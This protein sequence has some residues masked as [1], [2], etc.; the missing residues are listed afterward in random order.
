M[1]IQYSICGFVF[2][3]VRVDISYN[4]IDL[5]EFVSSSVCLSKCM[6]NSECEKRVLTAR[7]C[8]PHYWNQRRP[9]SRAMWP[10]DIEGYCM[11]SR[12]NIRDS[13]WGLRSMQPLT[14]SQAQIQGVRQLFRC[15][16]DRTEW[17]LCIRNG[18]VNK[19]HKSDW[20]EPFHLAKWS[21]IVWIRTTI[22]IMLWPLMSWPG[23]SCPSILW[24]LTAAFAGWSV[25]DASIWWWSW[26]IAEW[27]EIGIIGR[28]ND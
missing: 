28:L 7:E 17:L 22:D 14:L 13:I 20:S 25:I 4:K 23:I 24:S 5:F 6:A 8:C 18:T 9:S 21:Q 27:S 16:T 15:S 26:C 19:M 1:A 11:F 10:H 3:F 2:V 12:I